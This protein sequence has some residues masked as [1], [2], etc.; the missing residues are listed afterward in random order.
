MSSAAASV[1]PRPA[2]EQISALR[3]S[4]DPRQPVAFA[5]F[6]QEA[7]T[8]LARAGAPLTAAQDGSLDAAARTPLDQAAAA[9]SRL[10]PQSLVPRRGL[11]GLFD[12]RGGR[13]KRVRRAFQDT[14]RQ[15]A[16]LAGELRTH[17]TGLASRAGQLDPAQEALRQPII[18]LGGWIE[19][20]RQRLADVET[21][22]PEG[23]VSPHDQLSQRLE[24]LAGARV[25]ALAQLPLARQIQNA[26]A[27]A[28]AN[29]QATA[30]AI[31]AWSDGS[32]KALGLDGKR[33][34]KVQPQ[35]ADLAELSTR[36]QRTLDRAERALV[37][38]ARR[39]AQASERLASINASL[40][41]P[42][43]G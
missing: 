24:A 25:A 5:T 39:R 28:V 26:D 1:I 7:L 14:D 29:L 11:A 23:E 38:G 17:A 32:R 16:R 8:A 36:L 19:A 31:G 10:D 21:D 2:A 33:P 18:D 20:G 37:D 15:M 43:D 34:R 9:L 35:P 6:G 42:S 27:A 41:P 3:A 40:S 30:D 12:S 4:L 22:A 13:L